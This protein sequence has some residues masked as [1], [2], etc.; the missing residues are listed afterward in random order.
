MHHFVKVFFVVFFFALLVS[1]SWRNIGSI[2]FNHLLTLDVDIAEELSSAEYLS[3][4]LAR[5]SYSLSQFARLLLDDRSIASP[6]ATLK[7]AQFNFVNHD[8]L[9]A[10]EQ[11]RLLVHNPPENYPAYR[12]LLQIAI[13]YEAINDTEM[14]LDTYAQMWQVTLPDEYLAD[15]FFRRSK[16]LNEQSKSENSLEE[17]SSAYDLMPNSMPIVIWYSKVSLQ[18]GQKETALSLAKHAVSLAPRNKD[19]I[20]WLKEISELQ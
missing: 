8:Y 7:L 13:C 17:A 10:I 14:A 5:D 15:S 4:S 11:Y 6:E 2:R 18:N 3:P 1:A 16:I 20:S 19:A 12:S 9:A